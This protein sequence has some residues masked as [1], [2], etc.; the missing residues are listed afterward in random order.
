MYFLRGVAVQGV[1]L[2]SHD[3][4]EAYLPEDCPNGNLQF[5]LTSLLLIFR[6]YVMSISIRPNSGERKFQQNY[7]KQQLAFLHNGEQ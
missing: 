6:G 1:S 5:F 4:G 3:I 2:D 7:S